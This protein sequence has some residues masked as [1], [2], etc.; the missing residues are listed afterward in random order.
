MYLKPMP[1]SFSLRPYFAAMRSSMRVVL[2]A[3]TISP[4]HCLRFEQPLQ[5]DRKTFVRIDEAAV[6][7]DRADAVGVAVGRHARLAVLADHGL[8]Q[9]AMCGSM[10]SGLMPGNSGFSSPRI[11]K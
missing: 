4:G 10:G 7:G 8:L 9:L 5:N 2:K 1:H 6:F 3:R 11:S